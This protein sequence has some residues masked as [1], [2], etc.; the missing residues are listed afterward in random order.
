MTIKTFSVKSIICS[1]SVREGVLI[2]SFKYSWPMIGP[3]EVNPKE[4]CNSMSPVKDD[5][6]VSSNIVM[7]IIDADKS[8]T[9]PEEVI[10]SA[11]DSSKSPTAFNPAIIVHFL[12]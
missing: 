11:L 3:T 6:V 8:I 12:P 2:W 4:S 10:N 5:I 9:I 1:L 7:F